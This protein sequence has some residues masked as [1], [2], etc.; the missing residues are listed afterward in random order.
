MLSTDHPEFCAQQREI[1]HSRNGNSMLRTQKFCAQKMESF[2]NAREICLSAIFHIKSGNLTLKLKFR[3][4]FRNYGILEGLY[5][6][7]CHTLTVQFKKKKP[8]NWSFWLY[9]PHCF[10]QTS[11]SVFCLARFVSVPGCQY[12]YETVCSTLRVV[13]EW[14]HSHVFVMSCMLIAVLLWWCHHGRHFACIRENKSHN[15]SV[16]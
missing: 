7:Q 5:Y 15:I 12:I 1:L 4:K 11:T 2:P 9:L 6:G 10:V 13:R 14:K 3:A 8:C 16:T